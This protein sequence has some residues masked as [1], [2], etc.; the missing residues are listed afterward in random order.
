L[1]QLKQ[2]VNSSRM[3]DRPNLKAALIVF[4]GKNKFEIT[5]IQ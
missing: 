4:I 3:K 2:Y 1:E 5:E